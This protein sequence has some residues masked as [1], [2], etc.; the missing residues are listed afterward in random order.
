VSFRRHPHSPE[1]D[2]HGT[3]VSA[4]D[5]LGNRFA[6]GERVMYCIGAGRGQLMA[7]GDVIK[8]KSEVKHYRNVREPKPGETP[9]GVNQYTDPPK[10]YFVE[11]VPYDEVKVQVRTLFTAG[12]WDHRER[13][14]P[15]WVNAQN[16]TAITDFS[17]V[18]IP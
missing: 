18:K 14:T 9:T 1:Y 8:I 16:I 2:E 4:V 12:A 10:P 15:A 3:V 17:A 7:L 13:Q 11:Q 5:W 6:V